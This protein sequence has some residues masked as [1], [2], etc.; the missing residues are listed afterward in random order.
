MLSF[1]VVFSSLLYSPLCW[2][3]GSCRVTLYHFRA[4]NL[5]GHASVQDRDIGI[6]VFN[7]ACLLVRYLVPI[8][9]FYS[10]RRFKM[11]IGKVFL[12]MLWFKFLLSIPTCSNVFLWLL[13]CL[14]IN[15]TVPNI[16]TYI[17]ASPSIKY[18][19]VWRAKRI[20]KPKSTHRI[21]HVGVDVWR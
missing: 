1:Q 5:S 16:Y 10:Q 20:K 12:P 13:I 6:S 7:E 21:Q 2:G 8:G 18:L 11:Q 19:A 15:E 14:S 4:K 3:L 9:L 17:L